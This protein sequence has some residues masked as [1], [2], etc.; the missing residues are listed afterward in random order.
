LGG[1]KADWDALN[2]S[3]AVDGVK[4]AWTN[5]QNLC[6]SAGPVRSLVDQAEWNAV[7]QYLDVDNLI[8]YLL[9]NFYGGNSDWDDHNWYSARRRVAGAGYQFFASHGERTLE[10]RNA[11]KTGVNQ[12]DKP[13]R[14]YAALRGST[15]TTTAPLNSAN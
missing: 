4:T 12:A 9:L 13:S 2:S 6:S 11:D 5:L 1:E 8:D 15:V 7:L 10:L 3:E 14:I